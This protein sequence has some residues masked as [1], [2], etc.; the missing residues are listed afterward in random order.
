M[1]SRTITSVVTSD[2]IALNA[3][4]FGYAGHSMVT[5]HGAIQQIWWTDERIQTK[6]TREFIV[7]K[8]RADERF[9]LDRPVTFGDELT[10][11]KYIDWILEK[12][13]R[14]FLTLVETGVPDQIFGIIDDAWD[15]D[16]LPIPRKEVERLSLSYRK[17]DQLNRKFYS[18]QFGFLLRP[19]TS[20]AHIPYGPNEVIPLQYI[21]R[22]AP[23][24][25]LQTW[26][27][28]HLPQ[29]SDEIL[30]RRKIQLGT[31]D[32]ID[33]ILE[34]RFLADIATSKATQH[35]H[36]API[37]AS[38]TS[39]SNGF[40]LSTFEAEHTLKSFIDFRQAASLQKL[41]KAQR[42]EVCM[43]WLHC[44]AD[45]IVQ[46]HAQ[47][48]SHTTIMPSNILVDSNNQIAF[49]DVGSLKILQSDKR[50]DPVEVY[51]YTAPEKHAAARRALRV[52]QMSPDLSRPKY[53]QRRKMS[54]D[55]TWSLVSSKARLG[56]S[57]S[58]R[59]SVA[60]FDSTPPGL[61]MSKKNSIS[62]ESSNDSPI[63]PESSPIQPSRPPPPLPK[64]NVYMDS[65]HPLELGVFSSFTTTWNSLNSLPSPDSPPPISPTTLSTGTTPPLSTQKG[66]I[67]SLGCVYLDI[68]TYILKK[69]PT[70]FVKH[71]STK[72]KRTNS[73]PSLLATAAILSPYNTSSTLPTP[74]ASNQQ[75]SGTRLDFSFHA[76]HPK[77]ETWMD[78]LETESTLLQS[79]SPPDSSSFYNSIPPLLRLVRAML[80]K[81]PALRPSAVDVR[82]R[83]LD[84]L[85][86][87]AR[88]ENLCCTNNVPKERNKSLPK[89]PGR[90]PV[91]ISHDGPLLE[92]IDGA[93]VLM[94]GVS[95]VKGFNFGAMVR[96]ISEH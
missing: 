76:N 32:E 46:I 4:V 90:K 69:K 33:P 19:L 42:I 70:D 20:G 37:W 49:S 50:I 15:D 87:F 83:V 29:K 27:K 9:M 79:T 84:A 68:L 8:L 16:D 23:A 35:R 64:D 21:H 89:I 59:P 18:T 5:P 31:K 25:T 39:K 40:T 11:N 30:V 14:L 51:N 60:S 82:E 77:L 45:A 52:N 38:Y 6:V 44:L 22:L 1:T 86:S 47:G 73:D 17:D 62:S 92:R 55:S 72:H 85:V 12:A 56:S 67:Y 96:R 88:V 24:A 2:T 54:T 74:Q 66:D 94:K 3:A 65:L 26:L 43:T 7:S 28:M 95:F 48:Q 57:H 78:I 91:P 81:N 53:A 93:N 71:R 61:V 80:N 13:K 58:A 10:D 75:A 34:E 36:I 63:T 41:S